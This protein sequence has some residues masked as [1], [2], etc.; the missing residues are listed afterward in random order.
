[1][2]HE[3]SHTW[4]QLASDYPSETKRR[5]PAVRD[6]GCYQ[7]PACVCRWCSLK[8]LRKAWL[9]V[10]DALPSESRAAEPLHLRH[11]PTSVLSRS[12]QLR[13]FMPLSNYS[14]GSVC[15][16]STSH[17]PQVQSYSSPGRTGFFLTCHC[18][19][20][21]NTEQL[22]RLHPGV[23]PGHSWLWWWWGWGPGSLAHCLA[24]WRC[25]C[26]LH[27][28]L[29]ILGCSLRKETRFTCEHRE[30]THE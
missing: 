17:H 3:V 2:N 11:P 30:A 9:G 10:A 29:H 8:L 21:R 22:H 4:S 12:L 14:V 28:H 27:L 6:S 24:S 15:P 5:K 18:A 16:F 13:A 19:S 20:R 7:S 23:P 26:R 1:M 25:S